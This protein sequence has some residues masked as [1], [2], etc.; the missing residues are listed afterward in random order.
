MCLSNDTSSV[1]VDHFDGR[2]PAVVAHSL[3]EFLDAYVA[4]AE[5]LLDAVD[6]RRIQR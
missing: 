1:Q 5:G 3:A 2:P 4:D 6:I